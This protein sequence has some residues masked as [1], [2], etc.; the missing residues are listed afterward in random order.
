MKPPW[1]EGNSTR[2]FTP[3]ETRLVAVLALLACVS[4]AGA[5]RA[6]PSPPPP[7]PPGWAAFVRSVAAFAVGGSVGGG[8]VLVVRGGRALAHHEYGFAGR[9]PGPPAGERTL[10]PWASIT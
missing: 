1:K 9:A 5:Q 10:L 8:R 6:A 4:P 7:P 3:M 2:M